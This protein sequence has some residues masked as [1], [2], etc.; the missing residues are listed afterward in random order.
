MKLLKLEINAFRGATRPFVLD[1]DPARRL[2]MIFGEN[3][4]GKS[5][6]SDA[7]IC[8]CTNDHGSLDD[9][10]G[11]DKSYLL[12]AGSAPTS[13]YVR[14]H[15]D[16][17]RFSATLAGKKINKNSTGTPPT[18]RH[19]RRSSV[20]ALS[21]AAPAKRYEQLAEY[22]DLNNI[23]KSEDALR[24]LVT[25]TR[26]EVENT[27]R[28][29]AEGERILETFWI[30]DGSPQG[31]WERWVNT[32][33]QKD[34]DAQLA[35]LN[36]IRA[37]LDAWKRATIAHEN[38]IETQKSGLAAAENRQQCE[39]ALNQLQT[40]TS[41]HPNLLP[42]LE[43]ALHYLSSPHPQNNTCPVCTQPA[44]HATLLGSIKQQLESMTAL[45]TATAAVEAARTEHARLQAQWQGN[46]NTQL[47]EI[48][49]FLEAVEPL[50]KAPAFA[51]CLEQIKAPQHSSRERAEVFGKL[52]TDLDQFMLGKSSEADAIS[53][54]IDQQARLKV[55]W[56]SVQNSRTAAIKLTNLQKAAEEALKIVETSRKTYIEAE[57]TAISGDV[58]A[59]YQ[60][61]HP[62]E[63]I[64]D[65]RLFLKEKNKNSLELTA[66]FHNNTD[67]TP[68][69]LYSESHLDTLALCIFFALAKRYSG[70]HTILLLDDVLSACDDAH[71]DR[72]VT[73]LHDQAPCFAHILI[74]THYRPW[75]DRYRQQRAP[76]NEIHLLELLPWTPQ[77][78]IRHQ[79]G[80]NDLQ[81]LQ[82][83]MTDDAHFDRQRIANLAGTMLEN[84]L[85][86]LALRYARP[87]PYR[88]RREY[89][90]RELLDCFSGKLAAALRVEHFAR[91][92]SGKPDFNTVILNQQLQPILEDLKKLNAVRNQVGS[93]FNFDGSLVSDTDVRNFGEQVLALAQC[94]T[95]PESG[96]FP[97]RDKSGSWLETRSGLVR[98]HP[99][100]APA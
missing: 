86:N 54:T 71:L 84:I 7:L 48:N 39:A 94:L 85:E 11:A 98:L 46:L 1:F 44:D 19:L 92:A 8:L 28:L 6:I 49:R 100:Q 34:F 40:E 96:G 75:R 29:L 43:Q 63:N 64:G 83:A 69:S 87:L 55:N 81:E 35:Q 22:F 32:E 90:M 89:A 4:A 21:T 62:H 14:L 74:T 78:G 68:Q 30:E 5:S 33:V 24:K 79:N 61:L 66:R 57:L 26:T 41:Q 38:R 88:A 16:Q 2:T 23:V 15:T 59:L 42:L 12:A 95:C 58:D 70:P 36:T 60:C 80:K 51:S 56:Q 77:R 47:A 17:G 20:V 18:L 10:S 3:G 31:H 76:Q 13:L 37:A 93:H 50:P 45:R 67:I 72:F 9:K 91:D 52:L 73:L 65:I 99:L 27:I 25:T 97:D 53:K 82:H